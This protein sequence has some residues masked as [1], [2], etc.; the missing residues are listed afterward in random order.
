MSTDEYTRLM[1]RVRNA[2]RRAMLERRYNEI[3]LGKASEN[4]DGDIQRDGAS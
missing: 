1:R 3:I 2:N 4:D